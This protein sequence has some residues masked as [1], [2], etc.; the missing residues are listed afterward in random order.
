MS[1]S[2]LEEPGFKS[3]CR[4]V[5]SSV[6]VQPPCRNLGNFIHPISPA[7][8]N[9]HWPAWKGRPTPLQSHGPQSPMPPKESMTKEA[10]E[11]N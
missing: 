4:Q 7:P 3:R 6:L 2:G 10:A 11:V 9:P 8:S 1:N 5:G